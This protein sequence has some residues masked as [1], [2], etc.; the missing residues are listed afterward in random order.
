LLTSTESTIATFGH[1]T[2]VLATDSA[3]SIAWQKVQTNLDAI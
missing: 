3:P 2:A 1:D